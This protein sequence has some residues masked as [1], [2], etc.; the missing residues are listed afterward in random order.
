MALGRRGTH[1]GPTPIQG[2]RATG[3][4]SPDGKTVV[5][6][7]RD[8]KMK[9]LEAATGRELATLSEH[10]GLV[11]VARFSP[12]GTRLLLGLFDGSLKLADA[13]TGQ[14]L[15]TLARTSARS[16]TPPFRPTGP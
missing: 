1:S 16:R 12:D 5:S 3:V 8:V 11:P 7:T 10:A 15:A 4:F 14:E 2:P 9:L 13:A 6:R